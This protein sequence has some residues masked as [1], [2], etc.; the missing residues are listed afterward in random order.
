[1]SP[2]ALSESVVV[3]SSGSLAGQIFAGPGGEKIPN[4]GQLKADTILENGAEGKFTPP[5]SGLEVPATRR[6]VRERQGEPSLV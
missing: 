5:D 3:D 2:Q 6:L 1:M 4:E